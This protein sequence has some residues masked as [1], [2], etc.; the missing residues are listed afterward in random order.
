M[1]KYKF[2]TAGETGKVVY[3][4]I[5]EDDLFETFLELGSTQA[6]FCGHDHLN[7]FSVEYKGI[8]LTYGMSVDYLAYPGI[9]KLGTQRGCTVITVKTDGELGIDA[10]SYYDPKYVSQYDKEP[11]TMQELEQATK[12]DP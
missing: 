5:G 9:Y 8:R 6:V 11:V 4:G 7:N 3:C 2:G 1:V 10:M 12:I